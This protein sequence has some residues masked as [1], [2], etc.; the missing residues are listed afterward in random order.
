MVLRGTEAV[1]VTGFAALCAAVPTGGR[2]SKPSRASF[3]VA[4]RGFKLF[5]RFYSV[6]GTRFRALCAAVPTGGPFHAGVST[7]VRYAVPRFR[8]L[9][10]RRVRCCAAR[11]GAGRRSAFQAVPAFFPVAIRGSKLFPRFYSVGC[12]R[13]RCAVRSGAGRRSAFQAVRAFYSVA[14]RGFKLF[15]RFFSVGGTR[16][17]C[18]LRSCA[19]R[20]SA[21]QAVPA[22]CLR[23]PSAV[24]AVARH[25]AGRRCALS[26][27]L[28]FATLLAGRAVSSVGRALAF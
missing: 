1:G 13:F 4:I 6:G 5:P 7:P 14:I 16:F 17:R 12:T 23:R 10:R 28:L 11:S 27:L 25:S 15:P 24:F 2:R 20:R 18:A 9:L 26:A 3:P 22:L 19:D 8:V 21:F